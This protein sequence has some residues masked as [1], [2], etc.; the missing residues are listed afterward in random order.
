MSNAILNREAGI[1]VTGSK[2][3]DWNRSYREDGILESE[4]SNLADDLGETTEI[5]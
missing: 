4:K 3:R 2:D 5:R 1:P